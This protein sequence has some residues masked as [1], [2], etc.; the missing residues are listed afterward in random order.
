[1]SINEILKNNK[2]A[3]CTIPEL[4]FLW[5]GLKQFY[6]DGYCADD[7]PLTPYKNAHCNESPMGVTLT[8]QDLLRAIACKTFG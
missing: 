4:L 2:F 7:N 3:N 6:E 1:M 8:E 5:E